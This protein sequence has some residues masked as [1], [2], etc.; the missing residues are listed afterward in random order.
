MFLNLPPLLLGNRIGWAFY[1]H[2]FI[3]PDLF[4]GP[5]GMIYALHKQMSIIEC[6]AAPKAE[7]AIS[8]QIRTPIGQKYRSG[9]QGLIANERPPVKLGAMH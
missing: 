8:N 4:L 6:R 9:S 1:A 3:N 2:L 5:E 7:A